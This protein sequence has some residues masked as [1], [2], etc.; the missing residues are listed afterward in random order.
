[1]PSSD[2]NRYLAAI[3]A[4]NDAEERRAKELL[5]QIQADMI[6]KYGLSDNDVDYLIRQFRYHI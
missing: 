1:M 6:A 5:R 4:A 3:K 2:Y